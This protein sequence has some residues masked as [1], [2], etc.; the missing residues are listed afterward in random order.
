MVPI[1][2]TPQANWSVLALK[3]YGWNW[4][5]MVNCLHRIGT[6]SNTWWPPLGSPTHGNS[7]QNTGS[8]LKQW[9]DIPLSQEGNQLLT[10]LFCKAGIK[11]KELAMLNQY[12]MFLQVVT[13]ADISDGTGF[14]IADN[15]LA[16]QANTTFSLG[17]TWPNQQKPSK[18]DWARWHA[19]RQQAIPWTTWDASKSPWESGYYSGTNT[20]INGSHWLLKLEPLGLYHWQDGWQLHSLLNNQVTCQL[21]FSILAQRA[22]HPPPPMAKW[23]TCTI[24]RTHITTLGRQVPLIAPEQLPQWTWAEHLQQ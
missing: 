21:K 1:Q 20:Q 4:A 13:T 18:Q 2:M 11:G 5:L 16:G 12:C 3:H 8:R 23:V 24:T 9:P 17:Y 14:Y 22:I 7:K 10:A 19:G 6:H 15:M